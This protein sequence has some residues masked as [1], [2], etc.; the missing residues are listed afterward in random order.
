MKPLY[1]IAPVL[2]AMVAPLHASATSTATEASAPQQHEAAYQLFKKA[3]DTQ[4]LANSADPCPA[5]SIALKA[6]QD[7]FCIDSWMQRAA[8][9]GNAVALNY[10][11]AKHLFYVPEAQKQAPHVKEAVAKIKKAA[12]K[13]Y[14]PAMVDYSTF[15]RNGI[16]IIK[17][18]AGADRTLLDACK[19]G[20]FETRFSWLLQTDRLKEYKDLERPEVKGEIAR[21]NHHV[22]YYMS[23]KAPD[24]FT[25]LNMLTQAAR[26]GNHSAMY[27]LS[28][29]LS[30]SN[31]QA[32]Y[33]YLKSAAAHHNPM[34]ICTL[35]QYLVSPDEQ[36]S[37]A[38]GMQKDTA[39]GVYL[40]KTAAMLGN[41]TARSLLSHMYYHGLC[42]IT[43]NKEK[44]YRHVEEGA[45]ARPDV[46]FMAAQGLMLMQG[47]GVTKD[48]EK[49]LALIHLAA[50]QKYP[51]AIAMLAYINYKG[52]GPSANPKEAVYILESLATS[53][54]D[55]CFVFLAL[56]YDEG[57]EGLPKDSRKVDYYMGHATRAL[58]E[59]AQKVFDL[60][61]TQHNGWYLSPFD[62]PM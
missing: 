24:E 35:G 46:G 18:T 7:E 58:G 49:G 1:L 41:T 54:L 36:I 62:L 32:S 31:L 47:E 15:M 50:K 23:G 34:A 20:N 42:G 21:G 11:G 22:V 51:H 2:A 57:T 33:H 25:M 4:A 40:L 59:H 19:D 8:E 17:N 26:M 30:H 53:G 56:M 6:T 5:I 43:Q 39:A 10:T 44:A 29:H 45:A 61:K 3:L 28:V 60:H 27:E 12:D 48:E 55:V 52:I 37:E 38:L 13:K 9:E 14:V 16:G